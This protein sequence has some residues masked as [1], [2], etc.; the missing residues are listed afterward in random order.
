M[1]KIGKTLKELRKSNGFSIN[2]IIKKLAETNII[3]KQKTIY[4]WE[5]DTCIPNIE[6][7]NVLSH[8][9][10]ISLTSMYEDTAF[11]KSLNRHE[12][13][14]IN[15]LRSNK[16]FRRLAKQLTILNLSEED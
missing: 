14:F 5:N 12:N 7:I 8:I 11:C 16:A 4:K 15:H 6:T 3:V 10:G 9:Y 1:S 13:N 2:D